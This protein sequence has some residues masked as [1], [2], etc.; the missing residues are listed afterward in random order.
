[1]KIKNILLVLLTITTIT[2]T[3]LAVYFGINQKKEEESQIQ[4]L[5][6]QEENNEAVQNQEGQEKYSRIFKFDDEIN[7]VN[8][9][10]SDDSGIRYEMEKTLYL[11][12]G[13]QA[14]LTNNNTIRFWFSRAS[15]DLVNIQGLE[16]HY[17][18]NVYINFNDKKVQNFYCTLVFN[19][20][21]H[22]LFFLMEDGTIEYMPLEY[23]INNDDYR[24]YGK[25]EGIENITY[26]VSAVTENGTNTTLAVQ[27][28]GTAY[29]LEDQIN[30]IYFNQYP[31]Y[32]YQ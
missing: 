9:D 32:D 31:I 28:D 12:Y 24:S 2:S 25:I 26:L 18:N 14:F 5:K 20:N 10:F 3:S 15:D 22:F 21:S 13:I 16:K 27:K 6:T 23:A 1:M 11:P 7:V 17:N 29:D 19:G 8:K 4:D 30:D